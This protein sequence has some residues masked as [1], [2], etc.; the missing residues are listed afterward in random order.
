M[1]NLHGE[2]YVG[3]TFVKIGNT[4]TSRLARWDG[5]RWSS[6]GSFNGDVHSMTT[7]GES[8]LVGG[9]F[10]KVDGVAVQNIA[11]YYSGKW[12][13]IGGGLDG[14]VLALQN[15]GSCVYM[16]GTFTS[17]LSADGQELQATKYLTRWCE[18]ENG[19]Q[20]RFETFETFDTLG[21]VHVILPYS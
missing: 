14:T 3:G 9:D 1:A 8:L 19:G 16:G 4:T 17:S 21:P 15:V 6:I 11:K 7:D 2:L 10:T 5:R 20:E 13:G 12:T 18:S